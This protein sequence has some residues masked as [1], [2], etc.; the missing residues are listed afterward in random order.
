MDAR[1]FADQS[2]PNF[3]CKDCRILPLVR[4]DL[5]NH[6]RSG[7]LWL[8]S[9]DHGVVIRCPEQA[10]HWI[11][12]RSAEHVQHSLVRCRLEQTRRV[13]VEEATCGN[14]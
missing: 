6:Q 12:L 4:L 3:P 11:V 2:F 10:Q 1:T 13:A 9:A 5:V 8:G 14:S 7:Y